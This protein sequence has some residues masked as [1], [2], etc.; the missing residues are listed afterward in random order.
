MTILFG[1]LTQAFV[2]FGDIIM[3]AQ[4]GDAAAQAQV[5]TAA[6]N[7]RSASAQNAGWL[8]CIGKTTI[9]RSQQ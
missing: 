6:A 7:F 2:E 5:P 4:S 8:A 3:R 9:N 1:N